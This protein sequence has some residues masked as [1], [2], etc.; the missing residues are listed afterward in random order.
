MKIFLLSLAVAY[1]YCL[2]L[3]PDWFGGSWDDLL[4]ISFF[5]ANIIN[6]S[7]WSYVVIRHDDLDI[8]SL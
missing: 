5:V 6:L 2:V 1:I 8:H 7:V 3:H 4:Y